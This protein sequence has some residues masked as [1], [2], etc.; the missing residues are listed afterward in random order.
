MIKHGMAQLLPVLLKLFNLVLMQDV[1]PSTWCNR[2]ITPIFKSGPKSDPGNYRGIC[3][4]SCL[5]KLFCSI[6]N[7]RIARHLNIN[8]PTHRNQ[9]GFQPRSRTSD[10]LLTLKVLHDNFVKTRPRGKIFACFVDFRKAFDSIWH[11]GRTI[12]KTSPVKCRK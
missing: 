7:S 4:T 12:L 2:L 3:V 9:I 1:F 11:K 8:N 5:G 10:H 6:L